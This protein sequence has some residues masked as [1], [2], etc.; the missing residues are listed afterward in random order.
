MINSAKQTPK[1]CGCAQC[2]LGKTSEAGHII[3]KKEE[4][5]FRHR[6]KID[7]RKGQEDIPIAPRGTYTD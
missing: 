1:A 4:R 5:A 2:R 7:L 6:T 3:R